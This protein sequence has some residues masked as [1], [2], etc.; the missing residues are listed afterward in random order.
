MVKDSER[1]KEHAAAMAKKHGRPFQY[2]ASNIKKDETAR[3]LAQ[4]DGIQQG[5]GC[6][7]SILEPCRTFSFKFKKPQSGRAAKVLRN[8]IQN[9]LATAHC[10]LA[11]RKS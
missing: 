1:V 3:E 2:L 10:A 8:F 7:F 11:P 4:R 5:L 6:I 9:Y